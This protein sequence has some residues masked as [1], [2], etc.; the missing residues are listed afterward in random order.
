MASEFINRF[1]SRIARWSVGLGVAGA[2]LQS[3]LYTVDPGHRSV[4]FDRF[5]GIRPTVY[6]PGM[7]FYVPWFQ[8]P[9][10]MDVRVRPRVLTT[11]T[12]SKDLQEVNL[13]LRILSRPKEEKVR[14]V[15]QMVGLDFDERILPSIGNEVLKAVVAQYNADQLLTL[16]DKVSY[17]I[18]SALHR[19][20]EEFNLVLEDV[21]IT[22]LTFSKDFSQAIETKQVAHQMAE[23][24]KFVVQKAEQ[25][26]RA[27]IIQSEGDAEAAQLVSD[28]VA[29]HGRGLIELRKIETSLHMANIM[30]RS[31]NITYLPS[32]QNTLFNLN[33]KQ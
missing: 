31:P 3:S 6:A 18:R 2:A 1:A 21:S 22:H 5:Q 9:I 7:H 17:E 27:L 24:A 25:E 33:N 19:R 13:S 15:Y 10:I 20:A 23:R 32:A 30:A 26:K 16:R 12:A 29:K 14:E 4:L 8:Y 11:Q 28:A